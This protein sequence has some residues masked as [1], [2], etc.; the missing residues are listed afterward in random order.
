MIETLT[1]IQK[2]A[3]ISNILDDEDAHITVGWKERSESIQESLKKEKAFND[4]AEENLSQE[5]K[6]KIK[7][8]ARLFIRYELEQRK[9]G[10]SIH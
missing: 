9:T 4:W 5:E 10:E 3:N 7:E 2:L 6:D 1:R 8:V